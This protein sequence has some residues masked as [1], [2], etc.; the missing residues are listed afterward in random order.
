M[1]VHGLHE[2][3]HRLLI[4]FTRTNSFTLKKENSTIAF[5]IYMQIYVQLMALILKFGGF[6]S[7]AIFGK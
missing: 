6:E 2:D 7:L 4:R 3:S 1:T 5:N